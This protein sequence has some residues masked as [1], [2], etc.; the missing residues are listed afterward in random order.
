MNLVA[1]IS[2]SIVAHVTNQLDLSTPSDDIALNYI[3]ALKSGTGADQANA[4]FTDRRTLAASATEALDLSG[5]LAGPFGS[6]LAF[7]AI[8]EILVVAADANPGDLRVGK[9]V[10]NTFVGPFG[11]TA[12]GLLAPP[13]GIIH[14]RNPG[15]VG[16]PVV[17]ATGDL[18]EVE[19]LS[20]AGAATYDIIIIG[21]A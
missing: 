7:T 21:V 8:K 12:V 2:T 1:T 15:A 5:V 18:L 19:N 3:Q 11:A 9:G 14:L 13:S 6:V 16:W 4:I 10:T 20:S 17:A